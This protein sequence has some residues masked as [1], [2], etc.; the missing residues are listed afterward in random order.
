MKKREVIEWKIEARRMGIF[1][2]DNYIE[3]KDKICLCEFC[4]ELKVTCQL[5]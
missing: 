3:A 2:F 5:M 1:I 4:S